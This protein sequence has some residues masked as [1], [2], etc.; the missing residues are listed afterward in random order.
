MAPAWD[1]SSYAAGLLRD[2]GASAPA[3]SDLGHPAERWA[4]SGNM[5][6]TGYAADEAQMCPVPLATQADSI[7]ATLAALAGTVLPRGA[8]L[9]AERAALAGWQRGGEVAVGRSC[10]FL[11][12][13]DGHLALNL[14]RASDWQLLPAWLE[15]DAPDGWEQLATALS[16]RELAPTLARARLLGL[17]AAALSPP[18]LP[19]RAWC[20][21][22]PCRGPRARPAAAPLVVDL[23]ALWAGPLCTHLLSLMGARVIKVESAQ[24]PDG[25]RAAG[26]AF[27]DLLNG[28][29]QS[30]VLDFRDGSGRAALRELLARAD[31]VI[32]G[33]RP[34]ALRQ[35]GINAEELVSA[36]PGLTWLAISGYGRGEEGAGWV[37][38]GDDAAVAGGLSQVMYH[39]SGRLMFCGDAIGD[40]LTGLHAALAAWTAHRQGG[41]RLLS[42]AMSAV[43]ARTVR[44]AALG[45]AVQA[46]ERAAHWSARLRPSDIAA[47]R[48]RMPQ[49]AARP[50]GADTTAVLTQLL[51]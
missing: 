41:G 38:F 4:R 31:I 35:L 18:A 37:A 2:L 9:L 33:S 49:Q 3:I 47:P 34:R 8:E 20:T 23:S 7:A 19:Q 45:D 10:R 30:V 24:R 46:R 1:G 28:G 13:A 26:S 16:G 11:A 6:L 17:A 39:S 42:V 29:K 40:P 15:G 44:D 48:A 43:V 51:R 12:L 5:A 50:F 25:A 36:R 22:W 21:E 32:E 27:F 14:A